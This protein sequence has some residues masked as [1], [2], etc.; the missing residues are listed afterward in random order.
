M[1]SRLHLRKQAIYVLALQKNYRRE[2]RND[3]DQFTPQLSFNQAIEKTLLSSRNPD[4]GS[5]LWTT[6]SRCRCIIGHGEERNRKERARCECCFYGKV[7]NVFVRDII[8][9]GNSY[10]DSKQLIRHQPPP[11]KKQSLSKLLFPLRTS[12]QDTPITPFHHVDSR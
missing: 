12:S 5:I 8:D 3:F 4:A 11:Q 2:N 9:D 6:C 1:D 10:T 7:H